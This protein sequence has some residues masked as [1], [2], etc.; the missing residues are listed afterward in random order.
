MLNL[1]VTRNLAV[2]HSNQS[3][4]S[5][6]VSFVVRFGSPRARSR[7]AAREMTRPTITSY[8][9]FQSRHTHTHKI[10]NYAINVNVKSTDQKK[11]KRTL[12]YC[13]LVCCV[14]FSFVEPNGRCRCEFPGP[15]EDKSVR[16]VNFALE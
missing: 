6:V 4:I 9:S 12:P 1:S 16:S 10:S 15:D 5:S 14:G 2:I 8:S 3:V 13:F 7:N 11:V